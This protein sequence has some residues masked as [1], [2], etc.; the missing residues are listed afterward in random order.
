MTLQLTIIKFPPGITLADDRKTFG[1]Q[2]G[3][4]GRGVDNDWVLS[5]PERFLSSKHCQISKEGGQYYLT[6]L[7]TN[8]TFLNGAAEPLGRG[9]RVALNDGDCFDVGDY[10]FKVALETQEDAFAAHTFTSTSISPFANVKSNPTAFAQNDLPQNDFAQNGI[11]SPESMFMSSSYEGLVKDIVPDSMKIT[12]PLVALSQAAQAFDSGKPAAQSDSFGVTPY[13][14]DPFAVNPFVQS[15]SQGDSGDLLRE[16]VA[17]PE[18][19]QEQSIL[20]EDW[21][22]D[23]SL[24]GVGK[25]KSS[26]FTMRDEDALIKEA[27]DAFNV[28]ARPEPPFSKPVAKENPQTPKATPSPGGSARPRPQPEATN[29]SSSGSMDR[30]LLEALGLGDANL[31]DEQIRE[32][33]HTIGLMMRETLDGLMQVLRSRTS[34]KNEFRINITT[35]Q[36]VENNPIKFSVSV[37][38]I[39]DIMFLRR[40]RAYKAPLDAIEESF[41]SIADHQLAVIAGIRSAF[42]SVLARFDPERLEEEFKQTGKGGLLPGVLKGKLWNAYQD[43]YQRMV[44]D[45]ERSFQDLFGD[46]FVQAYEDQMRKLANA[47]KRDL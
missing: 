26:S 12:D 46:E 7:S 44:N 5:D 23:I 20:P 27:T 25:K 2:G 17:W 42:R 33:H 36:P 18:V 37:D 30:T 41:H 22:D 31:S 6:D 11:S 1:P 8:G 3:L 4:I 40:T 24:I 14:V 28:K 19:K 39:L 13:D 35:I 43:H 21:A 9:S 15:G 38:E 32:I 34:I 29:V 10:R 47:R 16:A 45:M